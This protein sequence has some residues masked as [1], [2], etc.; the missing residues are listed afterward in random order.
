MCSYASSGLG[1]NRHQTLCSSLVH[2]YR[3]QK[4]TCMQGVQ[5]DARKT[6]MRG[7]LA[8]VCT[9]CYLC[10]RYMLLNSFFVSCGVNAYVQMCLDL[11]AM[12]RGRKFPAKTPPQNPP[13][14]GVFDIGSRCRNQGYMTSRRTSTCCTSVFLRNALQRLVI[15]DSLYRLTHLRTPGS[16][17]CT[18]PKSIDSVIHL[19][20]SSGHFY[21]Y[22]PQ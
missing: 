19:S 6:S 9:L 14:P 10:E 22:K 20:D 15:L 3:V 17:A 8:V 11:Q 4:N 21:T 5:L 18:C 13:W 2:S 12:C 16:T 1:C 7:C